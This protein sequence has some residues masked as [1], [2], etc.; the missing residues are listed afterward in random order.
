[1]WLVGRGGHNRH[2]EGAGG[3]LGGV[4]AASVQLEF[5]T[6]SADAGAD[7]GLLGVQDLA[8]EGKRCPGIS[9]QK[10]E[11]QP[12]QAA[13]V[14][15]NRHPRRLVAHV[16]AVTPDASASDACLCLRPV[17]ERVAPAPRRSWNLG[18]RGRRA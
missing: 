17:H 4:G 3:G 10:V 11:R 6:Q 16:H 7:A 13:P 12:P 15:I 18:L 9:H 14:L 2:A 5:G 1:M 8:V